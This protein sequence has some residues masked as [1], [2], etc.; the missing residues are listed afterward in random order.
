MLDEIAP[1]TVHKEEGDWQRKRSKTL[2]YIKPIVNTNKNTESFLE[3]S[4]V[5]KEVTLSEDKPS[6]RN[7]Q[8]QLSHPSLSDIKQEYQENVIQ[9]KIHIQWNLNEDLKYC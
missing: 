9:E 1:K 2:N 4:P 8:N 3:T 7:C 6:Q 5:Q